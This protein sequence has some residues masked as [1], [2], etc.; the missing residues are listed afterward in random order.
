[1]RLDH[2]GNWRL[3]FKLTWRNSNEL[4][5]GLLK[6][7]LQV[8]FILHAFELLGTNVVNP[9]LFHIFPSYCKR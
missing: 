6:A 5:S 4:F 8:P 3:F 1:M 2:C 7:L 9:Q